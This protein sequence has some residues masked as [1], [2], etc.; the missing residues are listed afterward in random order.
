M[1]SQQCKATQRAAKTVSSFQVGSLYRICLLGSQNSGVDMR[2]ATL[3]NGHAGLFL[4]MQIV[5]GMWQVD[6]RLDRAEHGQKNQQKTHR[7]NISTDAQCCAVCFCHRTADNFNF[8]L[9]CHSIQIQIITISICVTLHF[10]HSSFVCPS[11]VS[12]IP[13]FHFHHFQQIGDKPDANE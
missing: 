5:F 9:D 1:K 13:L 2:H 6:I 8:I 3:D 10:S 7:S 4:D 11:H 12:P